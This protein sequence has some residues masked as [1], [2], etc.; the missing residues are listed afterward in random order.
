MFAE[1]LSREK[2]RFGAPPLWKI[3]E[4]SPF[5]N[6]RWQNR[7][8]SE[9][10]WHF[11][12]DNRTPGICSPRFGSFSLMFSASRNAAVE[13][14]VNRYQ[15]AS[16]LQSCS[17]CRS[18]SAHRIFFKFTGLFRHEEIR[19]LAKSSDRC[20]APASDCAVVFHQQCRPVDFKW[21][22][23]VLTSAWICDS[24]R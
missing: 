20:C 18:T 12:T 24:I 22:V 15:Q 4:N 16:G 13:Y 23:K 7:A 17:T 8:K 5:G 19:F 3:D 6:N 21:H 9:T 1:A 2:R 14:Y 10:L 11:G